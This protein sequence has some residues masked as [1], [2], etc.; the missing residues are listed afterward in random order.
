MGISKI[1]TNLQNKVSSIFFIYSP[2][3]FIG[4]CLLFLSYKNDLANSSKLIAFLG[5]ITACFW[6]LGL[7]TTKFSELKIQ[8]GA[9]RSKW[10]QVIQQTRQILLYAFWPLISVVSAIIWLRIITLD[11]LIQFPSITLPSQSYTWAAYIGAVIWTLGWWIV[12][13]IRE[14]P[15][16]KSLLTM[17]V[18]E[19]LKKDEPIPARMSIFRVFAILAVLILVNVLIPVR[20]VMNLFLIAAIHLMLCISFGPVVYWDIRFIRS[21]PTG[22]LFMFFVLNDIFLFLDA[23]GAE[24]IANYLGLSVNAY[25]DGR[26]AVAIALILA[27]F[28]AIFNFAQIYYAHLDHMNM[29]ENPAP[30]LVLFFGCGLVTI[31]IISLWTLTIQFL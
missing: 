15:D 10:H 21:I 19:F 9:P 13:L 16:K 4:Q 24:K 14:N 7:I 6:F 27:I 28:A 23:Q 12:I 26:F 29:K 11:N 30:V 2:Y 3:I 31:A 20:T 25:L 17:E 22:C 1:Y 5:L 8:Q 18:H